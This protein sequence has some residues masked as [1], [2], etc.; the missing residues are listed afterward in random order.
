MT[1]I[2]PGSYLRGTSGLA[3]RSDY[4]FRLN[5]PYILIEVEVEVTDIL[6][7][8]LGSDALVASNGGNEVSILC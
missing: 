7:P 2:S 3:D 4:A 5:L 8:V 6:I 1:A